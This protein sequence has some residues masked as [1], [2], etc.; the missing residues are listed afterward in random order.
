MKSLLYG[1]FP[2]TAR[3]LTELL[4]SAEPMRDRIIE[5]LTDYY[6]SEQMKARNYGKSDDFGPQTAGRDS[7]ETRRETL[8]LP[9]I[10]KML[11]AL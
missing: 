10:A 6:V 7:Q 2:L 9:V 8:Y 3:S 11:D 4:T 1:H 5:K